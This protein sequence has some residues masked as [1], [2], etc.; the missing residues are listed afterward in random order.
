MS[1]LHKI[2]L[3]ILINNFLKSKMNKETLIKLMQERGLAYPQFLRH[4]QENTAL[5]QWGTGKGEPYSL[6]PYRMERAGIKPGRLLPTSLEPAPNRYCYSYDEY[7]RVIHMIGDYRSI[8]FP[9][10]KE[11]L[12][13][14]D[15]YEYG[16]SHIIRYV[17]DTVFREGKDAKLSG[18]VWA[19]IDEDRR[20]Y[21][22]F[23]LE[24]KAYEYTEETYFYDGG[25]IVGIQLRW[26][27]IA[28][29]DIVY[30]IFHESGNVV[31]FESYENKGEKH[32]FDDRLGI[33]VY[34]SILTT[35]LLGT[36]HD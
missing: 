17:F 36:D 13:R 24:S 26:P 6:E 14:D 25:N 33:Q 10:N 12:H 19:N 2:S 20:I 18:V 11:W 5:T 1:V 16:E 23:H 29:P 22:S 32:S 30:K 31:I 35:A 3:D 7:G 8:G 27:E 9:D 4:A 21:K 34:P 28:H 15:F